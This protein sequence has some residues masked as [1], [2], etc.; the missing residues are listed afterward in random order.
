M[1]HIREYYS[2]DLQKIKE[3]NREEYPV[4]GQRDKL[5]DDFLIKFVGM[6]DDDKLVAFGGIKRIY[7]AVMVLEPKLS[8]RDK[9]D[10]MQQLMDYS[11][12][13][14]A[15]L[16]IKDWHAFVLNPEFLDILKKHYS[17]QECECK[18]LHKRL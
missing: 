17:F 12:L 10:S 8:T 1:I 18:V 15:Q 2:S 5:D 6:D 13:R 11:L 9:L 16:M 4:E 3:I 14:S 7:E